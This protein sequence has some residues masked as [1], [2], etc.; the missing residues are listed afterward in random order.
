MSASSLEMGGYQGGTYGGAG[1][2]VGG[3]PAVEVGDEQNNL[4]QQTRPRNGSGLS[5]RWKST[6]LVARFAN[7]LLNHRKKPKPLS[8]IEG[9]KAL[10]FSSKLNLLL[11]FLPIALGAG[12]TGAGDGPVFAL[13][14]LAL[15][16]L[17][18]LLGEATEKVAFHTNETVGGLL[19]ASFG[20]A[21]ELI[22]S[23]FALRAG[24]IGVVQVSLLG[25]ILSNLL[26]VM[27]CSFLTAGLRYKT[28]NF[29]LIAASSNTTL[30]NLACLSLMVPATLKLLDQIS[31]E[32][33]L[34][35]S[36]WISVLLLSVYGVF[37]YFQL[38]SHHELFD[39]NDHSEEGDE[40][41]EQ[42]ILPMSCALLWLAIITI[43]VAILSEMLTDSIEGTAEGWGMSE[44]VIGFVI[45]PILGNAAEHSTALMM[46]Y[47]GKMDLALSVALGSSTQIALFVIPLMVVVGFFMNAPMDLMFGAFETAITFVSVITA[48][49]VISNG[50][51]HYLHGVLLVTAYII[52]ALAFGMMK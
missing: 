39:E 28:A 45:L 12:V 27:G 10:L 1:G 46:S 22:V 2:V 50:V 52:I 4:L 37:V 15:L 31:A 21:T 14:C 16:P 24:L 18:Y 42:E 47:R 26:L 32:N 20:N 38:F 44:A 13:S 33:E 19:N 40:E 30:L 51:S 48:S 17:A 49:I 9:S 6:L 36:R 7:I 34:E 25:S 5:R 43:F 3:G 8:F 29:N 35:L 41:E 23:I 11:V